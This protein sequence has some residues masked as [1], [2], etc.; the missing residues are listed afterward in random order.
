MAINILRLQDDTNSDIFLEI[1][2]FIA[3]NDEFGTA[4]FNIEYPDVEVPF[5]VNL[6]IEKLKL[7]ANHLQWIILQYDKK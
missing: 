1:E 4:A 7:L 3:N 2:H 5:S 6:G